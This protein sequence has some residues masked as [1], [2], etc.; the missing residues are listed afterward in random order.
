MAQTKLG[1]LSELIALAREMEPLAR[2]KTTS[3]RNELDWGVSQVISAIGAM[4]KEEAERAKLLP[5]ELTIP[6]I[7]A[8]LAAIEEKLSKLAEPPIDSELIR[9]SA[10]IGE[11]APAADPEKRW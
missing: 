8:R 9:S 5:D 7:D 3:E 2:T 11:T 6:S 1:R 4:I 10:Q